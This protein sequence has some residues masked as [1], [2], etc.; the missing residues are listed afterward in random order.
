MAGDKLRIGLIGASTSY[1]W[2]MRSHLPALLALPE[3]EL[4][5]VC[6]S[7]PETAEESARA[8]GARLAFH[9]YTE[10]ANH[11]DVDLVSVSVRVPQHHAMV[12]AALQAGKHTFCEW[13]LGADLAEAEEMA[14]LARSKGVIGM[15]GLQAR[16]NP[17]LLR[18][19]ELVEEGYVGE[20]LSANMTMFLPGVLARGSGSAW[21]ADRTKGATALTIATGHSIDVLC[22]CLGEFKEV[23]AHVATQV[24][25]WEITDTGETVD[26]TAPDNIL[27]SG[28]LT[29]GAVAS[30]H[31]ASVP[32]HGSGW[33]MEVYGREGTLAASSGQMVQLTDQV[34]LRGGARDGALE[35]IPIPDRLTTIPGEVP[36]GSPINVAQLYRRLYEGI[37]QGKSADPDFDLA[38]TRHR[39]VDAIQRSSDQ[40]KAVQLA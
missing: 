21:Q 4:A 1:G 28:V 40:G 35:E 38:V 13:P 9:D 16:G 24:P 19:K 8:Y 11:P 32:W 36:G 18:L 30:A 20:V 25:T 37:N 3:Y 10:M 31:V 22:L 14:D 7:R 12:T 39:L 6:T 27:V 15:V 33:K 34:H 26:V 29:N 5:A 2:A 23:S 17:T